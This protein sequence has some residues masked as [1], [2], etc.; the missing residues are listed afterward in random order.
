[1]SVNTGEQDPFFD[2][3][4]V[5]AGEQS[6]QPPRLLMEIDGRDVLVSIQ[7]RDEEW[8]IFHDDAEYAKVKPE[9]A[10]LCGYFL[11]NPEEPISKNDLVVAANYLPDEPMYKRIASATRDVSLLRRLY[12]DK[13]NLAGYFLSMGNSTN[14]KYV[15]MRKHTALSDASVEFGIELPSNIKGRIALRGAAEV[16]PVTEEITANKPRRARNISTEMKHP[17]ATAKSY[18]E[19]LDKVLEIVTSESPMQLSQEG[20][21]RDVFIMFA[22]F[23]SDNTRG[24]NSVVGRYISLY[25]LVDLFLDVDVGRYPGEKPSHEELIQKVSAYYQDTKRQE[26]PVFGRIAFVVDQNE[27][28]IRRGFKFLIKKEDLALYAKLKYAVR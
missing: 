4:S 2:P 24:N 6:S 7:A 9:T 26:H 11:T 5:P 16:T 10:Q 23:V 14:T 13:D 27:P 22:R 18:N 3:T 1:M 21:E 20:I 15:L 28:D 8:F 17:V 12:A 25:D 19:A